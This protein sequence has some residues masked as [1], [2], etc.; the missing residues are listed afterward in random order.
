MGVLMKKITVL[1]P[2]RSYTSSA[3]GHLPKVPVSV[4]CPPWVKPSNEKET[5]K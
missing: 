5:E 2:N 1:V 3:D 4:S